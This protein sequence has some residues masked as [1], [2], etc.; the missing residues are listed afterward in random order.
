M[1]AA[2]NL[3]CKALGT[4]DSFQSILNSQNK[5]KLAIQSS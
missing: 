2:Q 4:I 3:I 1:E 5:I